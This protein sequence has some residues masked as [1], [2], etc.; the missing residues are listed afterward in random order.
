M[1]K[2][3]HIKK[4]DIFILSFF[5]VLFILIRS[6]YYLN[7]FNFVFDQVTSSTAVLDMWRN[8]SF[9]L[10]GPPL[11]FSIEGRQIF[12]GG[13]SYYIQ[14]IFLLLGK[15][16]PFWSAYI[17]MLFSAIMCIP[18]YIGIKRLINQNAAIICVLLY[19][20]LP[21]SIES[22]TTLWNPY[23]QYALLPLFIFLLSLL[24]KRSSPFIFFIMS[25][26]N[27]VLFQLHYMHIFT[28]LGLGIYFFAVK[29]LS[30]SYGLLYV[31]GLCIG[32]TNLILF[33]I[34]HGFYNLQTILFY[35][36]RSNQLGSHWLSLYYIQT[37]LFFLT[38][39]FIFFIR[40]FIT[41]KIVIAFFIVLLTLSIPFI[42]VTAQAMRY[43]KNWS[44]QDEIYAYSII[45]KNLQTYKNFNIFE[46]Y[47]AKGETLKYFLKKDGI[48]IDFNDYYH[49][50]HLYVVYHDNSFLKDPAYEVN[51]FQPS[52]IVLI[53]K[54]NNF[55]SLYLL[56]RSK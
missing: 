26:L 1:R 6:I 15:F 24:Q 45:K 30:W 56:K 25:V 54:I 52:E 3:F 47:I 28:I 55:Y 4:T 12:F 19:C 48:F 16:D 7:S 43:P 36:S 2:F 20:L 29:K 50:K 53:W 27:G 44:Y 51:S 18:L 8:R 13:I 40:K 49:N 39:I 10:I 37:E 35:L 23:F 32:I 38:I 31:L 46:F 9:T 21:F 17:F 14:L 41:S 22:T 11:S 34:R 33:E 5:V 42:T